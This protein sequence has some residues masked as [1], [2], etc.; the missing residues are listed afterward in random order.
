MTTT[1]TRPTSNSAAL[2]P[3]MERTITR[4]TEVAGPTAVFGAPVERGETTVIPCCRVSVG[5]GFGGGGGAGPA[6]AEE[7]QGETQTDQT[8]TSQVPTA[9]G[10][11]IGGGGGSQGRPVAAIILT[12]G[13]VQIRP[14]V[15]V[16]RVAFA[17]MATAVALALVI[18][19]VL[20]A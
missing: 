7:A 20:R 10:E 16:T 14:I 5:L 18:G 17:G 1:M 8:Q 11:G 9:T 12:P 3:L 2:A 6:R 19:R 4:L 13:R 15:D